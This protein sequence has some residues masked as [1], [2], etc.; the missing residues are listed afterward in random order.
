MKKLR[1]TDTGKKKQHEIDNLSKQ[2]IRRTPEGK[3]KQK[4]IDKLSKKK[5]EKHL[6]E[7]TN[8]R[9]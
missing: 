2:K 5:S 3:E 8:K 6:R 1:L 4:E 9:K 7:R